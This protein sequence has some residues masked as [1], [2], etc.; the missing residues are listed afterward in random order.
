LWRSCHA[1]AWGEGVFL[2]EERAD[3]QRYLA[4]TPVIYA[5]E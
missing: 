2:I 5:Q 1:A 4:L 3:W